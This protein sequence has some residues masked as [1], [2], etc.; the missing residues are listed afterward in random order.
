MGAMTTVT[1]TNEQEPEEAMSNNT[2]GAIATS[3]STAASPIRRGDS[4]KSGAGEREPW[5]L[6][7]TPLSA[8]EKEYPE[9]TTMAK[10]RPRWEHLTSTLLVHHS[11]TPLAKMQR[12]LWLGEVVDPRLLYAEMHLRRVLREANRANIKLVMAQEVASLAI[13]EAGYIE[14]LTSMTLS[15][16]A[17]LAPIVAGI[18][19]VAPLREKAIEEGMTQEFYEKAMEEILPHCEAIREVAAPLYSSIATSPNHLFYTLLPPTMRGNERFWEVARSLPRRDGLASAMGVARA[20]IASMA[21]SQLRDTLAANKGS[22]KGNRFQ[23]RE[24]LRGDVEGF[25]SAERGRI[26]AAA[27][28]LFKWAEINGNGVFCS[29]GAELES[30]T[31]FI[32]LS[33]MDVVDEYNMEWAVASF[34][35]GSGE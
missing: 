12:Q 17:I 23:V 34:D 10:A 13:R 4:N 24:A 5:R 22:M 25:S 29:M 16:S 3:P 33:F 8:L 27:K 21:V 32:L 15:R 2:R 1:T 26:V 11:M 9:F 6:D 35:W 30:F 20:K 31:P 28:M 7:D 14:P 19:A 18:A